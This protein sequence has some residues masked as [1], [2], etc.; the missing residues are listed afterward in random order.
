MI[1]INGLEMPDH[2]ADW[3]FLFEFQNVGP[4]VDLI[5]NVGL[6][7]SVE[8]G[9]HG[10]PIEVRSARNVSAQDR[11]GIVV[12]QLGQ[13]VILD[14]IATHLPLEFC[15]GEP[16]RLGKY[17]VIDSTVRSPRSVVKLTLHPLGHVLDTPGNAC[18]LEPEIQIT[19]S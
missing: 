14:E 15:Q 6:G 3:R 17:V 4:L 16:S 5:L 2:R 19:R 8:M 18:P 13:N 12:V 11:S 7:R 1:K 9:H 10:M